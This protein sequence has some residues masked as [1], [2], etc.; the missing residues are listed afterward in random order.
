MI[1]VAARYEPGGNRLQLAQGYARRGVV[2]SDRQLFPRAVLLR[3]LRKGD[4]L[5]TGRV[6]QLEGDFEILAQVRLEGSD[7]D[8]AFLVAD[9]PEA[10]GDD[11]ALPL[12]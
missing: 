12:F 8:G 7:T 9:G 4:R 2:W 3:R 1:L 11:L 5:A 6:A 10:S